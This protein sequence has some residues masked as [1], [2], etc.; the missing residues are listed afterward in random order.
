MSSQLAPIALLVTL[1]VGGAAGWFARGSG[2]SAPVPGSASPEV[3]ADRPSG[4]SPDDGAEPLA[5]VS[6]A[7]EAAVEE[8][9][10][11]PAE[12]ITSDDPFGPALMAYARKG[13]G[14]GWRSARPDEPREDEVEIGVTRFE[15]QTRALPFILGRQLAKRRT[16]AEQA[17]EDARTGGLFSV[18][19]QLQASEVEGPLFELVDSPKVFDEFFQSTSQG[20]GADGRSVMRDGEPPA[21][22][23][24]LEFPAGVFELPDFGGTSAWRQ[25]YPRDITIR[26]AG[27]D[28]T[29]LVLRSDLS[30]YQRVRNL[31][32]ENC[33]I[34]ADNNYMFDIRQP[35]MSLTIRR[36]RLVA[37]QAGAGSS[38]LFGTEALALRCV[39]TE[40]TG[41][42]NRIMSSGQFFDVRH[43]G[44]LARFDNC[45]I[46]ATRPFESFSD[47]GTVLFSNCR[48]TNLLAWGPPQIPQGV[49]LVGS[50]LQWY[51]G[52]DP[53]TLKRDLNELFPDWKRRLER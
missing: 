24:I 32:I 16:D 12:V 23:T 49:R 48:M 41:A 37:W 7:R 14:E 11:E 52:E 6:G 20:S 28:A 43:P 47:G 18:L 26:G 3:A 36:A 39:D 27:R 42:Y 10:R 46:D 33:T 53:E 21:D 45:T 34:N 8:D 1:L 35:A 30:A 19:E 38:C 5:P 9:D 17:V 4:G 50:P 51:D 15:E 25:R 40:I 31:T 13:I 22:G 29:M 2:P 44:L